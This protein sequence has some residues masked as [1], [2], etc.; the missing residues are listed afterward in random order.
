MAP[1][2]LKAAY[3]DK[4]RLELVWRNEPPLHEHAVAE[5]ARFAVIDGRRWSVRLPTE[6]ARAELG[7]VMN[8]PAFAAL[9]DFTLATASLEDVYLALGVA[10]SLDRE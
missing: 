1:G 6:E 4:V 8:G 10:A 3:S 5:L 7:K 9:D 2:R